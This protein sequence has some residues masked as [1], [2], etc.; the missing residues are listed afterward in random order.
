MYGHSAKCVLETSNYIMHSLALINATYDC[1]CPQPVNGEFVDCL[2]LH[3]ATRASAGTMGSPAPTTAEKE[4]FPN[5]T[6]DSK[7]TGQSFNMFPNANS[8]PG[9]LPTQAGS[10]LETAT[11]M[12]TTHPTLRVFPET[13]FPSSHIQVQ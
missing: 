5:P 1:L 9:M 10:T 4:M 11:Q 7:T 8:Q 12:G 13:S 6:V 3:L 2:E